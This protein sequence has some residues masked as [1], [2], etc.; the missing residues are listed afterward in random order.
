MPK[1]IHLVTSKLLFGLPQLGAPNNP[2]D[3]LAL[4]PLP[5]L[6]C[7]DPMLGSFTPLQPP[8]CEY[9]VLSFTVLG[10]GILTL[11]QRGE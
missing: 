2:P 4:S 3:T 11:R 6:L 5:H 9:C 8:C 7:P 10:Q 1:D